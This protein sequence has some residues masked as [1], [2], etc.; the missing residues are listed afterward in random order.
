VPGLYLFYNY[1]ER[2]ACNHGTNYRLKTLKELAERRAAAAAAKK[3]LLKKFETAPKPGDPDMV[4]KRSE[5][6]A[7]A[8][9]RETRRVERER[10]V[11]EERDR[12]IVEAAAVGRAAS[13][14]ADALEAEAKN[15]IARVATDKAE[16]KTERDRRYAARKAKQR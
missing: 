11:Q 12:Q 8:A 1:S 5:R 6:E 16:R 3:L 9:A 13:A 7:V 15:R 2:N 14:Q 4:A 10:S